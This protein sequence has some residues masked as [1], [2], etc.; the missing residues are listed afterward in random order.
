MKGL[1]GGLPVYGLGRNAVFA[2]ICLLQVTKQSW[3][4]QRQTN[5]TELAELSYLSNYFKSFLRPGLVILL[6]QLN[7]VRLV[8]A[9]AVLLTPTK[10]A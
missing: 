8:V 9:L 7:S 10:F 1:P 3:R 2:F 6:P 5:G 4:K